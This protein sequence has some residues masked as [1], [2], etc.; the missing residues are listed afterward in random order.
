MKRNFSI[1]AALVLGVVVALAGRAGAEMLAN[2]TG[3]GL[4]IVG[5][6]ACVALSVTTSSAATS[7]DAILKGKKYMVIA[8]VATYLRVDATATVAAG[9]RVPAD[10]PID[11][12]FKASSATSNPVVHGITA[13]G[14]G[15]LQFCP[16]TQTR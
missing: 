8:T 9:V 6:D 15:T 1:L 13:S 5:K 7:A 4:E 3:S 2:E 11:L 10:T 14:S 12:A 16:I